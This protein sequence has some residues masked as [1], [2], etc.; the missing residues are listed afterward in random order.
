M[1]QGPRVERGMVE[2]TG[3]QYVLALNSFIRTCHISSVPSRVPPYSTSTHSPIGYF[4]VLENLTFDS[5]D[6]SEP[7]A[8]R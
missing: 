6:I 1:V 8:D 3:S 4:P 5:R 2:L 7:H